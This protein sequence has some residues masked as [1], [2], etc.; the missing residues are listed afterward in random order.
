MTSAGRADE[1]SDL[2]AQWQ[3]LQQQIGTI[4][5]QL[6][7]MTGKAQHQQA[8]ED[9][10]ALVSVLDYGA[11]PT[12]AISSTAAFTAALAVSNKVYF[13]RGTYTGPFVVKTNTWILGED[14]TNTVLQ[15]SFG[16]LITSSGTTLFEVRLENLTL[17]S[18]TGGGDVINLDVA[19]SISKLYLYHLIVNQENSTQHAISV[20]SSAIN[21]EIDGV[22]ADDIEVNHYNNTANSINVVASLMG[23]DTWDHIA[24][25]NGLSSTAWAIYVS[26]TGGSSSVGNSFN[27]ISLEEPYGGGVRL[28]SLCQTSVSVRAYDAPNPIRHPTLSVGKSSASVSLNPVQ[29]TIHDSFLASGSSSSIPD[30]WLDPTNIQSTTITNSRIT[31]LNANDNPTTEVGSNIAH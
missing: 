30:V 18:D 25:T 27:N 22:Q 24:I 3:A 7:Q 13:P 19:L 4:Q 28:E 20:T 26:A 2:K 11:D 5:Q 17:D 29:T 21:G 1:L 31:W 16:D 15:T 9:P 23:F 8:S 12:G 6:K 10:R 14:K